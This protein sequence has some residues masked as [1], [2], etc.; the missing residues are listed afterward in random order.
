MFKILKFQENNIFIY[1][2]VSLIV[3]L[4]LIFRFYNVGYENLWFDEIFSFWVTDPNLSFS[5]TFSR[6]KSTETIPFLYYYLI[7]VCNSLFGYDPIVGRVFSALF[8]FLSIFTI[9]NLCNKFVNNKSNLLVLCLASLNIYLIIYSQEMRVYIFTFFL[10][11]LALIFFFNLYDEEKSQILTKNFIF[12]CFF[13]LLAIFSHPFSIIILSSLICFILIDYLFFK[14]K[15][16]KINASLI[17]TFIFTLFFLFNYLGYISTEKVSWITQPELKFFSNF[18][19]SKFFGSKFLGISHL[20]ALIFL[21]LYLR[22]KII[23]NKK[24]IFLYIMLFS[25]YFIPLIYGYFVKPIIFPKYIMFVL[26]PIILIISILI[27]YIENKKLR[28]FLIF[29][30]I[31]LN[32]GNHLTESTFK[33]FFNEKK[34]FNPDFDTAFKMIKGSDT[35]KMIFFREKNNNQNPDYHGLVLLNYAQVIINNKGHGI[36]IINNNLESYKGKIWNI[37]LTSPINECFEPSKDIKVTSENFLQ[38]GLK[39]SLWEIK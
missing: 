5:E 16:Q 39:L 1:F 10:I 28:S 11:S 15:N 17:L 18:Y 14:K 29:F 33:Q 32:L 35:N 2:S 19:F 30:F 34:K 21:S 27:F 3:L 36:N 4:G 23:N 38:G 37:C 12:F 6:I 25:S 20:I 24:I 13:I 22:K 31:F 8:G 26:I 7:K 9:S